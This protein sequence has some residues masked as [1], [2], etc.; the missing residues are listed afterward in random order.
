[1]EKGMQSSIIRNHFYRW[2]FISMPI[3][4]VSLFWNQL[5]TLLALSSG[6]SANQQQTLPAPFLIKDIYTNTITTDPRNFTGVSGTIYFH[7]TEPT[8]GFELWKSDG[9]VTG[10]VM[11][12]Q[13]NPLGDGIG[14]GEQE[15]IQI[16]GVLYFVANDGVHG[17]ELWRSDGTEE[18]TRMVKD[19][20]PAGNAF[21]TYSSPELIRIG[22]LIYFAAT[23]DVDGLELWRSD[24]SEEGTVQIANINPAGDSFP[25]NFTEM[26]GVLFFSADSGGYQRELWRSDGTEAGTALVA[27]FYD[28]GIY[29]PNHLAVMSQTLYFSAGKMGFGVEL[30]QSDGTLTGTVLVRD[31]VSGP[32]SSSPNQLTV[33][34]ETLF[35]TA[36]TNLGR[37]LWR[38]D[39]THEG[40]VM[41]RDI[42]A[43]FWS[44]DP[45]NLFVFGDLLVF[46]A[47]DGIH[48]RELW[49]SDGTG[50]G[51]SLIK[52]INPNGGSVSFDLFMVVLNN[53]LF[54]N[55]TDDFNEDK[56]WQSD[57][58]EAG[59]TMVLG[60]D[61]TPIA[62]PRFIT[63][64]DGILYFSASDRRY[65]SEPWRSDGTAVGT[66]MIKDINTAT[67]GS[68]AADGD[69]SHRPLPVG[70]MVF[71]AAND[72]YSG[73]ELWVSDRTTTNTFAVTNLPSSGLDYAFVNNITEGNDGV[74]YFTYQDAGFN[75]SLWRMDILSYDSSPLVTTTA[76]LDSLIPVNDLLF[77]VNRTIYESQL[78]VTDGSLTGTTFMVNEVGDLAAFNNALY[79]SRSELWM[80]DGTVANT[81]QVTNIHPDF[82]AWGLVQA[83]DLLFFSADDQVHG[84]ELWVSD[85]TA[86]GTRLVRDIRPGASSS[87]FHYSVAVGD[88]VYFAANDG[89]HGEE[90][91]VSD[92][93]Q[94]GTYLVK[95]IHLDGSSFPTAMRAGNGRLFFIADDGIHGKEIWVS[96]GTEAGTYMV[97]DVN[98]NGDAAIYDYLTT[99]SLNDLYF[100][101][102]DDG[103]HGVELW[104]SDGTEMGTFLITDLNPH[105]DAFAL[106]TA[107]MAG[108]GQWLY[109]SA[110]DGFS[111]NELWALDVNL[112][113]SYGVVLSGDAQASGFPGQVITYVLTA[114]NTG[115]MPDTIDLSVLATWMVDL[116]TSGLFLEPGE[117]TVFT[118]TVQIPASIDDGDS[119][120]AIIHAVSRNDPETVDTAVLTT[121]AYLHKLYLP[122]LI[123]P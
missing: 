27:G 4:L 75:T 65:S 54:F 98:P 84:R 42:Y 14:Y 62:S 107:G 103:V 111:G 71:F 20:N 81:V 120:T 58:S 59:T 56:L 44:S 92:G 114:T 8:S 22:D 117:Q 26:E 97:K 80:S 104:V 17:Y 67:G 72:G 12:K 25:Q 110:S 35:F 13:I 109:F 112:F 10:T 21:F 74:L 115:S 49:K 96:D 30:W 86:A 88:R 38:S 106:F 122:I 69:G 60:A 87:G 1:M 113:M 90:L 5:T 93:T 89:Q 52:N 83:G 118:V 70:D 19:I 73:A 94:A 123:Q 100:I 2:F 39:G 51:T 47:N 78:W 53:T 34:N 3:L 9:T 76:N 33:W 40:T 36:Q 50:G 68:G 63:A 6:Q 121:T 23:N 16:D 102:L 32:G 57:G 77:F 46:A 15:M 91:W 24:G 116:P 95:D 108:K 7:A 37:E 28:S 41:V 61:L 48:G 66:Y 64:I 31:I 79:F 105:G 85:G 43:G 55:A 99:Y 11:V 119:D 101:S 82:G 18:G 45:Q 29:N